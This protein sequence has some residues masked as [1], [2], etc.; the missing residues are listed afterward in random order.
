MSELV[1][2]IMAVHNEDEKFLQDAINSILN[3]TYCNLEFIIVNDY[4]EDATKRVLE[5]FMAKENRIIVINNPQNLG[6][7]KSLNI[8]LKHCIGNYIARMDADDIAHPRRIEKQIDY[9]KNHVDVDL[10]GCINVNLDDLSYR[11][12]YIWENREMQRAKLVFWNGLFGHPTVMIKKVFLDENMVKYDEEYSKSQDYK[13]WIDCLNKGAEI[14]STNEVLLIKRNHTNQISNKHGKEQSNS[15]V[16]IRWNQLQLITQDISEN[17][18]KLLTDFVDARYESIDF[19]HLERVINKIEEGNKVS[20]YVNAREFRFQLLLR[21]FLAYRGSKG[22]IDKKNRKYLL[23]KLLCFQGI[24]VICKF[25]TENNK[26][27][28]IIESFKCNFDGWGI[29]QL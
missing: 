5:D 23:K 21:Y 15:S 13:L 29:V 11:H 20:G 24:I 7:T 18:A 28:N 8:A 6:L 2:V 12:G 9:L 17:E 4:S 1:S 25:V 3:Q 26:R 22:K 10:V 27:N 14:R 19:E 16:K